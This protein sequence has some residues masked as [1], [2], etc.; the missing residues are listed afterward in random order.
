MRHKQDKHLLYC[1]FH[2]PTTLLLPSESSYSSPGY[3]GAQHEDQA[4]LS[5]REPPVKEEKADVDLGGSKW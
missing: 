1:Y 4:S 2:T 5:L 3:S